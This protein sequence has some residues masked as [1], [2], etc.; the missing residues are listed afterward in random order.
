MHNTRNLTD[1]I[2]WVGGEDRRLAL[3]ENLF[4]IPQGIA[5]HSYCIQDE[6]TALIDT[7]DAS[8]SQQFLENVQHA[9]QG[10]P[11]DYLIIQHMEP[12]HCAN[13]ESL[14]LRY[15]H[16]TLVG[17][18]RTLAF[19]RQFYSI[20]ITGRTLEVEDGST[21][22]LGRHTLHFY[23]TPMV[24]WPEVMMSYE[25]REKI[26]F[27]ADAFGSFG[28]LDGKLFSDEVDMQRD[29]MPEARRYYANIVGK[30]GP[31]VQA[32]LKKLSGLELCMVCPLHGRIWR[33]DLDKLLDQTSRWSR[34]V[35][36]EQAAVIIYGSMYGNTENAAAL[37]AASLAASGHPAAVYDVSRTHVST[38]I[39]EIFRCSHLV[40]ASPTYNNGIYPPIMNLIHDM[41]ALNLESR[42]VALI[43]NGTWAPVSARQM[44]GLIGEMADMR[45]LE[46]A[47]TI[48]SSLKPG[49]RAALEGMK[50]RLVQSL[51]TPL[52]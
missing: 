15:P 37:L 44:A 45:L 27:S 26:L 2:L 31:Q 17:N 24:H 11:L 46:P 16:L 35:P 21:L 3:F 13:I 42:T 52:S 41:R 9:L 28:A 36:E 5:Y 18:S 20:D 19:I 39:A 34:Y 22:P 12:D 30:Y 49:S 25:S 14:L 43:E 8:I 48:Q 7:V 32:A 38:L 40:L 47:V 51:Q 50:D 23:L 33:R 10:R 4:P 29:W 1:G 6:K